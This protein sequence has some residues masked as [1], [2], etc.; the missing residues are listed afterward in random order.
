MAVW[1][2]RFAWRENVGWQPE[3]AVIIFVSCGRIASLAGSAQP[4]VAAQTGR[5]GL[6][7][8]A[9]SCASPRSRYCTDRRGPGCRHGQSPTWAWLAEYSARNLFV[10]FRHADAAAARV[11]DAALGNT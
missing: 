8:S 3:V 10:R 6:A 7:L 4:M 9:V 1:P 2:S 11:M 5:K